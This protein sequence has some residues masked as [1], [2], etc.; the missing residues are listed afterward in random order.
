MGSVW[1]HPG[2]ADCR[3]LPEYKVAEARPDLKHIVI[4]DLQNV[5]VVNSH[6]FRH[7]V[8]RLI[9]FMDSLP[10]STWFYKECENQNIPILFVMYPGEVHSHG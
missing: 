9:N 8:F 1:G 3:N 4:T 7:Q 6:K 2:F 10:K 5:S